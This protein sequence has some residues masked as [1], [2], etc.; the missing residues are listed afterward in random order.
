MY[1][2]KE[3]MV[4]HAEQYSQAYST[5]KKNNSNYSF[6]SKDFDSMAMKTMLRQLISKWGVMSTEMKSAFE[7]DM[8]VLHDD[9]T[10]YVDNVPDVVIETVSAEVVQGSLTQDEIEH[11]FKL[12][13]GK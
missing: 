11:G 5:D 8:A 13:G 2:S 3:K 6:W 4:K 9:K 7:K 12:D 10:E 1:W